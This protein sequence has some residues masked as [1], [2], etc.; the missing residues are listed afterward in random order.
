M[1]GNPVQ[2]QLLFFAMIPVAAYAGLRGRGV[3]VPAAM[4]IATSVA[5]LELAWNS[6]RLGRVETFSLLSLLLFSVLG[7]LALLRSDER[8]F[9]LQPVLLDLGLAGVFLYAWYGNGVAL[10]EVILDRHVGLFDALPSYQRGYASLYATTLSRSLPWL[11]LVHAALTAEAALRR[12]NAW[13]F[14]VRVPGFYL[15]LGALFLVERMLGVKP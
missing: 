1:S 9:K 15:V 12:S 14:V 3:A 7:G 11:L 6:L 5:A 4:G 8:L 10:L 13:W 2:W